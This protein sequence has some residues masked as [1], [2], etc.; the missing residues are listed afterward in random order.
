MKQQC[1]KPLK[2]CC[3]NNNIINDYCLSAS[4]HLS[5]VIFHKIHFIIGKHVYDGVGFQTIRSAFICAEQSIYIVRILTPFVWQTTYRCVRLIGFMTLWW[6][7]TRAE[8]DTTAHTSVYI[9]PEAKTGER[10]S[11]P[12]LMWMC[13]HYIHLT[14]RM[15]IK[16][17]RTNKECSRE[18]PLF[19]ISQMHHKSISITKSYSHNR[20]ARAS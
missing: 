18:F 6:T 11:P 13:R 17:E 3:R 9:K 14:T 10:K 8:N 2:R 7:K 4:M 5:V 16:G 15:Y 1:E 19:G 20:V 12:Q